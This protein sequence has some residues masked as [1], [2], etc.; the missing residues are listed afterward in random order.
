MHGARGHLSSGF[1]G[2][3]KQ[4]REKE[5]M[6]HLIC[7]LF[8]YLHINHEATTI[9]SLI[10]N[11]DS[12]KKMESHILYM[13]INTLNALLSNLGGVMRTVNRHN[14]PA[15]L[16]K[17]AMTYF[18]ATYKDTTTPSCLSKLTQQTPNYITV[19]NQIE[20]NNESLSFSLHRHR[21]SPRRNHRCSKRC[22]VSL[23]SPLYRWDFHHRSKWVVLQ[24]SIFGGAGLLNSRKYRLR[25]C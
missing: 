13:G 23:Q 20:A 1:W 18:S 3:L 25:L 2:G 15:L 9:R 10:N 22:P 6:N 21:R 7:S 5:F 24:V 19:P 11:E 4:P 14:T 17:H 8:V 16:A 12:F